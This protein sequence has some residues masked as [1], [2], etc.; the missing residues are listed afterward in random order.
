MLEDSLDPKN[1]Y[2]GTPGGFIST[3]KYTLVKLGRLVTWSLYLVLGDR[4]I[5]LDITSWYFGGKTYDVD[6]EPQKERSPSDNIICS[7]FQFWTIRS[8]KKNAVPT[9]RGLFRR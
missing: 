7:S 5:C 1:T 2:L 9:T 6:S 4:P 3:E 8:L